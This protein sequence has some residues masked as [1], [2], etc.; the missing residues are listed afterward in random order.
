VVGIFQKLKR[1]QQSGLFQD[2]FMKAAGI[3]TNEAHLQR[4][5]DF[6]PGVSKS[7][8][9]TEDDLCKLFAMAHISIDERSRV[10]GKLA[11]GLKSQLAF[12]TRAFSKRLFRTCFNL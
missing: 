1:D 3:F 11:S 12:R 2:T 7:V 8:R 9:F 10:I 6:L 5:L 4:V